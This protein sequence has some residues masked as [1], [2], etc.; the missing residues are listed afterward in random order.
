MSERQHRKYLQTRQEI[1]DYLSVSV[2]TVDEWRREK[3]LPT[4]TVGRRVCALPEDLDEFMAR[5][6]REGRKATRR[7]S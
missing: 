1:A 3:G 4:G 5:L 6:I 7:T 2:E